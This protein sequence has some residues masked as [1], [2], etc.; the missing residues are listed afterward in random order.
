MEEP[1]TTTSLVPPS[2]TAAA[3]RTSGLST[4]AVHYTLSGVRAATADR[5]AV[6]RRSIG[7]TRRH[8]DGG[9][10]AANRDEMRSSVPTELPGAAAVASTCR[11]SCDM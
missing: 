11:M 10:D 6:W 7:P 1:R 5:T 4:R 2:A 9:R 8:V 3:V